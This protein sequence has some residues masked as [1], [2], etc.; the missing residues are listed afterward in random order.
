MGYVVTFIDFT[1]CG[2]HCTDV[3]VYGQFEISL[4]SVRMA[5]LELRAGSCKHGNADLSGTTLRQEIKS[6]AKQ[7]RV[8]TSKCQHGL[9]SLQCRFEK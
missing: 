3:F 4:H 6:R 9:L 8:N 1:S 2:V 5:N 7:N